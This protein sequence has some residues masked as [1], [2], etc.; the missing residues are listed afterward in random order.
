[1]VSDYELK[2]WHGFSTLNRHAIEA[3][4]QIGCFFCERI[5]AP[6]EF[7]IKEWIDEKP[8]HGAVSDTPRVENGNATALCP[9]CGIDS[10]L[11]LNV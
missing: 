1:M 8:R 3:S 11:L 7:P 9:F 10:I 5:W 4:D 2:R 6:L